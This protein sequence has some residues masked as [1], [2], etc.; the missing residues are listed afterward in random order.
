MISVHPGESEAIVAWRRVRNLQIYSNGLS[1]SIPD[2]T[3]GL[4]AETFQGQEG[5]GRGREEKRRE[6]GRAWGRRKEVMV[7]NVEITCKS[8]ADAFVA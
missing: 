4:A 3:A 6:G 1:G 7:R 2:A 8:Y 5:E